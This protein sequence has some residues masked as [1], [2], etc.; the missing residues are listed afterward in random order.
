MEKED[1]QQLIGK[2]IKLFL[3]SGRM[4]TGKILQ[5]N[6]SSLTF[7]D[8]FNETVFVELTSISEISFVKGG[9]Q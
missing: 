9:S 4:Y 7:L 2:P 1:L 6:K 5:L 3:K 8:K